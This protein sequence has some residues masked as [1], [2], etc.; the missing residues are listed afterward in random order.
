L[1]TPFTREE[2]GYTRN[3]EGN[4]LGLALVKK[5]CDLNG[6]EIKFSSTKGKG[7]IFRVTFSRQS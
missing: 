2:Q 3:Y 6:A 5:Y 7:T 1:F 4:G